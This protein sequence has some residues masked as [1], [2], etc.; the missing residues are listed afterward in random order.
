MLP[1]PGIPSDAVSG[2]AFNQAMRPARSFAGA[3]FFA[4]IG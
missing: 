1:T 3:V 2:L 4:T